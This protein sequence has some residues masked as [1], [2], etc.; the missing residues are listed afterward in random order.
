MKHILVAAALA[1][2]LSTSAYAAS[3]PVN[4]TSTAAISGTAAGVIFF[5]TMAATTGLATAGVG[6]AVGLGTVVVLGSTEPGREILNGVGNGVCYLL[7]PFD[8]CEGSPV[9]PG[10]TTTKKK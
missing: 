5:N 6:A 3:A 1:S 10:P 7:S 4:S 2:A 8:A 9:A